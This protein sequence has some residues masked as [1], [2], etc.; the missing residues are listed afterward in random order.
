[1]LVAGGRRLVNESPSDKGYAMLPVDAGIMSA[2]CAVRGTR[3]V[4][5]DPYDRVVSF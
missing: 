4:V 1:M 3:R 2:V 5:L